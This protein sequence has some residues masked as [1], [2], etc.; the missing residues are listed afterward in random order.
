MN[1]RFCQH[2]HFEGHRQGYCRLFGA[3]VDGAL[4]MCGV[5]LPPFGKP[6]KLPL[7]LRPRLEVEPSGL[8]HTH[9]QRHNHQTVTVRLR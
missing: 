5:A 4:S 9:S 8:K 1:C 3:I 7:R 2:Y 6:V